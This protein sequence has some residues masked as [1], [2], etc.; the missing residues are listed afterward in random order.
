[1]FSPEDPALHWKSVVGFFR[2]NAQVIV[3][4]QA[5]NSPAAEVKAEVAMKNMKYVASAFAL[6]M[7]LGI[8]SQSF[9][10]DKHKDGEVTP[11]DSASR[12]AAD[13]DLLKN[14][15][16]T[17][18]SDSVFAE[19]FNRK[20]T[21]FDGTEIPDQ[22]ITVNEL[23]AI[24]KFLKMS[25]T[26]RLSLKG[27]S[28]ESADIF[29]KV[30]DQHMQMLVDAFYDETNQK[31]KDVRNVQSRFVST[32][33]WSVEAYFNAQ[34]T[35]FNHTEMDKWNKDYLDA[36]KAAFKALTTEDYSTEKWAALGLK[37][38]ARLV[39]VEEAK[40][41]QSIKDTDA[42]VS[43]LKGSET[44][45]LVKPV[46]KPTSSPTPVAPAA[47]VTPTPSATPK[48]ERVALNAA[49]PL[50]GNTP[51]VSPSP[52]AA[53]T[54]AP[55]VNPNTNIAPPPAN[56][57]LDQALANLDGDIN[58]DLA[59]K[60]AELARLKRQLDDQLAEIDRLNRD[61][62]ALV[63]DRNNNDNA[64]ADALKA[65]GQ[66]NDTPPFIPQ[67]QQPQVA[68]NDNGKDD[69]PV[70]TPQDQQQDPNQ[71]QQ[72]GYNPFQQQPQATPL[73]T[74]SNG[75]NNGNL[76]DD[77]YKN[78]RD[79][80][81]VSENAVALKTLQDLMASNRELA[82]QRMMMQQGQNPYG[83]TVAGRM[84]NVGSSRNGRPVGRTMKNASAKN[85]QQNQ[86][87]LSP[88]GRSST[89]P[90]S[91]KARTGSVTR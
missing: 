17:L 71:G 91:L 7:L 6:A 56:P 68:N 5:K 81:S 14:K 86:M 48:P 12:P 78:K 20:V 60:A 51:V 67:Q 38:P 2:A 76:F 72:Q 43:A 10:D 61:R 11:V 62:N 63:N 46:V 54:N 90:S 87:A 3:V 16:F 73:I 59:A 23:T 22:K 80:P 30:M 88:M 32:Y 4:S 9:A 13:A 21:K 69:T 34:K 84:G 8:P 64:L 79:L 57:G 42:A 41:D 35:K 52:S 66:R 18:L 31:L 26:M 15:K 29:A 27:C 1:M 70:Q 28:D 82:D 45:C 37:N 89:V 19:T 25:E 36:T 33:L 74:T 85:G 49:P 83:N 40:L 58:G 39:P 75:N 53:P 24:K 50:G 44:A 47:T 65:L 55:L 77:L